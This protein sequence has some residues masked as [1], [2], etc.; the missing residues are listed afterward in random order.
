MCRVISFP[1]NST[2]FSS[3]MENHNVY[4]IHIILWKKNKHIPPQQSNFHALKITRVSCC[5][6]LL[7]LLWVYCVFTD[8]AKLCHVRHTFF[9]NIPCMIYEPGLNFTRFYYRCMH[10]LS[11]ERNKLFQRESLLLWN[12]SKLSLF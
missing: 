9:V 2:N 5:F 10:T 12:I 8:F 3:T 4:T 6:L 7:L 1:F 11:K